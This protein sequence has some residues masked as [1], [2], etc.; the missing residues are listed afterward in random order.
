MANTVKKLLIVGEGMSGKTSLIQS[1]LEQ[2]GGNPGSAN[3]IKNSNSDFSLKIVKID[4]E[5]VRMQV[6]DQGHSKDPI[7]TFQPLYIRHAAGCI[8]VA[9]T[10]N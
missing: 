3:M 4:G 2:D 5:K 9:N 10:T 6:W 7:S 8:V 1:F